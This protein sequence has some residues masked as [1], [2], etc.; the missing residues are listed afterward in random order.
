M[1]QDYHVMNTLC[2]SF[3]DD[4]IKCAEASEHA[5]KIHTQVAHHNASMIWQGIWKK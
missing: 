5:A 1:G 3:Q 2:N 4:M